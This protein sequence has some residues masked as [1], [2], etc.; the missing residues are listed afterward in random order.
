M[1]QDKLTIG[2]REWLSLPDLGIPAIRAKTDTGARTSALHTFYLET[3]QDETG[4]LKV[5]FGVHPLRQR[6]DVEIICTA[7]VID[8]RVVRSSGGHETERVVYSYARATW[9][10]DLAH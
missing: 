7:D 8:Q 3:F 5:K 1:G 2:W 9:Q 6:T 10:P 4:Q